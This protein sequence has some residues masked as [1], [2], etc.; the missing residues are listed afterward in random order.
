MGR[1][2]VL[3]AADSAAV[4]NRI[5][6][7]LEAQAVEVTA[8]ECGAQ[9]MEH[10]SR[11]TPDLVICDVALAEGDGYAVC[12]FVRRDPRLHDTPVV[13]TAA[14][15]SGAVLQRAAGAGSTC[16]VFEP[17]EA[18][19]VARMVSDL[20]AGRME[21]QR[22][23]DTDRTAPLAPL[24]LTSA[25]E[26][27]LAIPGVRSTVLVDR[28]GFVIEAGGDGELATD[29]LAALAARVAE[30]SADGAGELGQGALD[31]TVLEYESSALVFQTVARAATLI[32]LVDDP[33]S[34]GAVRRAAKRA[35]PQ[36]AEALGLGEGAPA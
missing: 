29:R 1:V 7:T 32:V 20:V 9:A 27:L 6:R 10:L 14:R 3:L 13:L 5:T 25:L 30:A 24:Q 36:L 15:P 11:E 12:E 8:A 26:R 34:L 16:V 4:R 23:V 19:N 35:L 28:D 18:E 21:D 2:R 22:R 33:A 31:G 17:L